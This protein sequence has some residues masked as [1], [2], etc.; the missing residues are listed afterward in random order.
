MSTTP[1]PV[2]TQAEPAQC[3]HLN[4]QGQ[5]HCR[6]G[7]KP[8]ARFCFLHDPARQ[9]EAAEARR[10]GG[11]QRNY[12]IAPAEPCDLSTAEAQRRVLEET[13]N[14]LRARQEPVTVARTVI[15]A[16]A[17]ARAILDQEQL[18]ARIEALE[19]GQEQEGTDSRQ[20]WVPRYHA[21]AYEEDGR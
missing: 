19:A 5:F 12:P 3:M 6:A 18:L 9:E 11:E 1:T 7:L 17:T 16:V 15:Y 14:R 2:S 8:G 21:P 13:I 4:A 20:A 10:K